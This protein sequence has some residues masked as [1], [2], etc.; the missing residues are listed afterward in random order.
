MSVWLS[1]RVL[2]NVKTIERLKALRIWLRVV[3][4][5]DLIRQPQLQ[6]EKSYFVMIQKLIAPNNI[7]IPPDLRDYHSSEPLISPVILL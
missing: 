3:F 1:R 5:L 7:G 4:W 2:G 6:T